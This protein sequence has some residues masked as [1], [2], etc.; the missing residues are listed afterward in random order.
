M[1]MVLA[2]VLTEGARNLL[3][4]AKPGDLL[5]CFVGV[6]IGPP[7]LS[8]METDTYTGVTVQDEAAVTGREIWYA[9]SGGIGLEWVAFTTLAHLTHLL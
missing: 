2:E 7:V 1:D 4:A 3:Q 9:L 8:A 5:Q 6:M